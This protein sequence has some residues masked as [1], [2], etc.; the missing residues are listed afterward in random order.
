[1]NMKKRNTRNGKY[2]AISIPLDRNAGTGNVCFN[3]NDLVKFDRDFLF[4]QEVDG[5]KYSKVLEKE[6]VRDHMLPICVHRKADE[7]TG[8]PGP[9]I[10]FYIL[11]VEEILNY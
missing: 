3:I 6:W 10:N 2:Y 11:K 8:K 1:M 9:I 5:V 7:K 4:E